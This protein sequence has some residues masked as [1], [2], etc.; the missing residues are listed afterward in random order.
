MS[1]N[2]SEW[3]ETGTQKQ[4]PQHKSDA[5]KFRLVLLNSFKTMRCS[6]I[7]VPPSCCQILLHLACPKKVLTT[8]LRFPWLRYGSWTANMVPDHG[9]TIASNDPQNKKT[10][11]EHDCGKAMTWI[12]EEEGT[13]ALKVLS[14]WIRGSALGA[15][16]QSQLSPTSYSITTWLS[17]E[18]SVSAG[19][20][21]RNHLH[22]YRIP[23]STKLQ[24]TSTATCHTRAIGRI[25]DGHNY[26]AVWNTVPGCR[27][28]CCK[29]MQ[30][31]I[32]PEQMLMI[33]RHLTEICD[34][35]RH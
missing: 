9:E 5:S 8:A 18:S 10:V 19:R 3:L 28:K 12:L 26:Q 27:F 21:L 31:H 7:S 22:S 23:A 35:V 24:R 16:H 25:D 15:S 20:L 11:T 13:V 33:H 17:G 6:A 34:E 4:Q 29:C 1:W 32:F 2:S 14:T 30:L